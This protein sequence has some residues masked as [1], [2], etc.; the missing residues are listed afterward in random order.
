MKK[1]LVVFSFW[2]LAIILVPLITLA[3]TAPVTPSSSPMLDKLQIVGGAAG[4]DNT[5][6]E[7]TVLEVVGAGISIGLSLLGVIFIIL[8]LIAGYNRMTAAGDEEKITKSNKTIREAIIG[9]LIIVASY[10]IWMFISNIVIGEP[11]IG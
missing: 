10:A 2:T 1:I 3:Q 4:F 11:T 5:T 9:L 6:D 7:S 8:I